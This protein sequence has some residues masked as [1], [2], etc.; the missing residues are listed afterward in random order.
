[1]KKKLSKGFLRRVFF[2]SATI[3]ILFIPNQ[4]HAFPAYGFT[5]TI[6]DY[7]DSGAGP[8]SGHYW[9]TWNGTSGSYSNPVSIDFVLGD[10][11]DYP[12]AYANFLSLLT[13]SYVTV[14]FVDETII[15]GIENDIFIRD[16][17]E[18]G[19]RVDVFVS[20]DSVNFTFLGT[21]I[22]NV[23]TSLDLASIGFTNQV[24]A[25][26]IVG[27]DSLGG[28]PGFDV[29]NIEVLPG[30]INMIPPSIPVPG[31]LLLGSL[32]V[33]FVSWMRRNRIL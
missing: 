29:I 15:D 2:Y 23:T 25:I 17:G 22:D 7:F 27:L 18:N 20:P 1:M 28:S 31:A 10:D 21:A 32:G 8:M 6:L 9:S 30:S 12:P 19:E 11:L 33:G 16:V 13:G 24:Q 5:V 14:G 4:A 26:K 3:A